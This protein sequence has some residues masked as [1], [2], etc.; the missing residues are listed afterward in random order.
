M[1]F[2]ENE[3]M[4]DF[5]A[6]MLH[7]PSSPFATAVDLDG[8]VE[9]MV[10]SDANVVVGVRP[11][12]IHSSKHG[13]LDS[14][15]RIHRPIDQQDYRYFRRQ[16]DEQEYVLNGALYLFKWSFFAEHGKVLADPDNI[17]AYSM[18]PYYSVEIDQPIDLAW[19]R[20]LVDAGYIDMGHWLDE[21][22]NESN[23]EM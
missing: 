10:A 18:D 9:M 21:E 13:V 22:I 17:Y 2:I 14:E 15:S 16:D 8:A 3:I 7:E 23:T 5:D 19:A 4:D 20:F 1:N 11:V 6:V 12:D